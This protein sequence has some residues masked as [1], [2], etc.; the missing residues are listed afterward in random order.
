MKEGACIFR[1]QWCD[2]CAGDQFGFAKRFK[3]QAVHFMDSTIAYTYR[4]TVGMADGHGV[5]EWLPHL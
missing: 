3:Q 1:N 4:Q 5:G 2:R